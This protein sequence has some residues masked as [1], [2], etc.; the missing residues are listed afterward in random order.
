MKDLVTDEAYRCE[1]KILERK[2]GSND[3]FEGTHV[4]E[5]CGSFFHLSSDRKVKKYEYIYRVHRCESS[6]PT[7][8]EIEKVLDGWGERGWQ[9]VSFTEANSLDGLGKVFQLILKR[10]K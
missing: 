10:E 6:D 3:Y 1:H 2:H 4:C 8:Y 7:F 5:K 9:L